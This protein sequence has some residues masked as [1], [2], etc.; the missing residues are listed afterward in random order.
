VTGTVM[1][2]GRLDTK[3]MIAAHPHVAGMADRVVLA[4][5]VGVA[6]WLIHR[7]YR[8]WKDGKKTLAL[9]AELR[10]S[11]KAVKDLERKLMMLEATDLN[12]SVDPENQVQSTTPALRLPHSTPLHVFL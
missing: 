7:R 2:W 3:E 6:T 10:N 5:G 11:V 1:K 9:E 8:Q 12:E 4:L